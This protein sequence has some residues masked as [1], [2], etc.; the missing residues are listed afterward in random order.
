[1]KLLL[2][3]CLTSIFL[4]THKAEAFEISES[5]ERRCSTGKKAVF[6][7]SS[8]NWKTFQDKVLFEHGLEIEQRVSPD[9]VSPHVVLIQ[10]DGLSKN[11]VLHRKK[12][13][14]QCKKL[15]DYFRL[16]DSNRREIKNEEVS[17]QSYYD[18]YENPS[19]TSEDGLLLRAFNFNFRDADNSCVNTAKF[20]KKH[21]F[22]EAERLIAKGFIDRINNSGTA[23]ANEISTDNYAS[24]IIPTSTK[25]RAG[26]CVYVKL[27]STKIGKEFVRLSIRELTENKP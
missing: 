18:F 17:K 12:Y 4:F 24:T 22:S 20:M 21:S 2:V 10:S 27:K 19:L 3:F 25:N 6:L 8:G 9:S 26:L 5:G 11:V 16:R 7:S 13:T 15:L 23:I 14:E 1:M